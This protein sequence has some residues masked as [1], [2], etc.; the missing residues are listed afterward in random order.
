MPRTEGSQNL[1]FSVLGFFK[2]II[3]FIYF[4]FGCV[5]SSLLCALQLSLVGGELGL[6]F[7]AV[8]GLLIAVASPVAEHRL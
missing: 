1:E 7:I 5:E 4:I 6:L 8:H 3:L 2:K